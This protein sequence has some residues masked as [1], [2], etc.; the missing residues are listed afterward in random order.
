MPNPEPSVT[1]SSSPLPLRARER[2][3][4]G[5]VADPGVELEGRGQPALQLEAAPRPRQRLRSARLPGPP[6]ALE[7]RAGHDDAVD[8]GAGEA[9]REAVGVREPHDEPCHLLDELR[10][11]HR[12][13]RAQLHAV[14]DEL[15]LRVDE[16]RLE[17]RRPDVDADGER[18]LAG[19]AAAPH[20]ATAVD[21]EALE[22]AKHE[23]RPVADLAVVGE[24]R[25]PVRSSSAPQGDA[26]LEA[27]ERGA[28]AVVQPEAEAEVR[29]RVA[30]E[31]QRRRVVE[32]QRVA[33]RAR[34]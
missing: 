34:R 25:S 18:R 14:A 22:P 9:E 10:R 7:V 30:V 26:G 8:D 5:V 31:A 32:D 12:P 21:V 1:V 4:V 3:H 17:R 6:A 24:R 15:A 13:R 19:D 33:V 20:A 16:R 27:R 11:R 2:G 29:V 28:E 23:V